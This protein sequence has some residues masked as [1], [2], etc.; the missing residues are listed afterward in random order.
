MT[1]AKKQLNYFGTG[2]PVV[3][4]VLGDIKKGE[5]FAVPDSSGPWDVFE[6]VRDFTCTNWTENCGQGKYLRSER[7]GSPETLPRLDWS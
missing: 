4:Y 5:L 6:A 7:L 3:R 2:A 1:K